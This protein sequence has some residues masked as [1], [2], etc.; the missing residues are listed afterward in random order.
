MKRINL[1]ESQ[2]R[3]ELLTD[4]YAIYLKLD[5]CYPA[6]KYFMRKLDKLLK[7]AIFPQQE[8]RFFYKD[9]LYYLNKRKIEAQHTGDMKR[10]AKYEMNIQYYN[11][12]LQ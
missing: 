12:K 10:A 1:Y 9:L 8:I 7:Q 5:T 4:R 3:L 2:E 6:P 11:Q